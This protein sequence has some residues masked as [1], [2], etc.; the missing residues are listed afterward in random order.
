MH[1]ECEDTRLRLAGEQHV[2]QHGLFLLNE[3]ASANARVEPVEHEVD[4]T[5]RVERLDVGVTDEHGHVP[6]CHGDR[7]LPQVHDK[8]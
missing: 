6:L 8:R 4:D 1:V 3:H 7:R 5:L 2:E